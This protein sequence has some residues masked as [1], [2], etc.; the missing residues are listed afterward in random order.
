MTAAIEDAKEETKALYQWARDKTGEREAGIFDAQVLFLEDPELIGLA[1]AAV[2]SERA[3]AGQAWQTATQT[4]VARLSA[5][6]DPY[7][8]ARAADVADAAARVMRR[9]AALTVASLELT[10]PSI[11]AAH[12]LAPSD[13]RNLDPAKV[14]G[15]CLE[16]GAASAHSVILARAVGLPVVVGLGPALSALPEGTT[17]ALDG[18]QGVLW[19]SPEPDQ[20]SLIESRRETWLSARRA[21]QQERN[22][23]AATR[24]GR[25]IRVLANISSV[26]EAVEALEH[27]AEGVGVLRTEF[28]FLGRMEAPGE[29]EQL[30]AYRGIAESLHGRPLVIRTLDVGGDKS[31]PY[32]RIGEEANP[33]LGWRGIRLTLGLADL[34]RTQLRAILRAAAERPVELLLPMVSSVD[35]VR[36]VRTILAE[37]E[38][39]LEREGL[40]F[41]KNMRVGVMI[42]VPSAVAV[43]DRLARKA[44]FFSIGT[45]DLIQYA[46]AADRTN[47][48]VAAIADPFQPA[49]LRLIRQTIEAAREAGIEVALCGE[50]AADPLATPLLIGLGLEELSVSAGLIP[51]L[52]RAIARWTVRDAEALARDAMAL[53]SG[54]AVRQLLMN[55]GGTG[56]ARA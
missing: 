6:E 19:V 38:A 15:L 8:R 51:G 47:A 4:M 42:E 24:D 1:S 16:T 32:I 29:E 14:M 36:A 41:R 44:D 10:Q 33:F 5:L 56:W 46:M 22:R 27:G 49:V 25:R 43:A 2:L 48:R 13:V 26:A 45:N 17:V 11:L 37:I 50:L 31:L 39:G 20:V 18:E 9:L 3:D 21:A 35:E 54:A 40:A 23:P 30:A 28:L 53:D 34:F 52:K 12:D 55:A 7:L